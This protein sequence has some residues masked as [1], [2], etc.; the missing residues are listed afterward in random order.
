MTKTKVNIIR[1]AI[2]ALLLIGVFVETGIFTLLALVFVFLGLEVSAFIINRALAKYTAVIEE[3]NEML[4]A[5]RVILPG[6]VK[7]TVRP[8]HFHPEVQNYIVQ[9][10][11]ANIRNK[12]KLYQGKRR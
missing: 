12:G 4:D 6:V 9:L 3:T 2:T 7:G 8:E 1:F 5:I 10:I 11:G